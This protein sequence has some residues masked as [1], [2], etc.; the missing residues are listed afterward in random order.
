MKSMKISN[1]GSKLPHETD[2]FGKFFRKSCKSGVFDFC[3][4]TFS[5]YRGYT[6]I[7]NVRFFFIQDFQPNLEVFAKIEIFIFKRISSQ[8]KASLA[9][10]VPKPSM[11]QSCTYCAEAF[12]LFGWY[13][14]ATRDL[15]LSTSTLL[16]G[17]LGFP[18]YRSKVDFIQGYRPRYSAAHCPTLNKIDTGSGARSFVRLY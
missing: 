13:P 12:K 15:T 10:T 11:R 2:T 6:R 7:Q 5:N 9:R 4:Q 17:T 3:E 18:V 8:K 16:V 14:V 1:F